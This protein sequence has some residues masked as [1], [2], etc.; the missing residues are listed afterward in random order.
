MRRGSSKLFFGVKTMTEDLASG[1]ASGMKRQI[2]L[3]EQLLFN[4]NCAYTVFPQYSV[5]IHG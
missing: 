3:T 5:R 2:A 1:L 4:F